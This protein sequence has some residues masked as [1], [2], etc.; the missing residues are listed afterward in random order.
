MANSSSSGSIIPKTV[1]PDL[2]KERQNASFNVEDFALWWHGGPEKLKI[3]RH[4]GKC[5]LMERV[6]VNRVHSVFKSDLN[7]API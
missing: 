7:I 4:M 6:T 1:N 5:K 2:Q 3:K